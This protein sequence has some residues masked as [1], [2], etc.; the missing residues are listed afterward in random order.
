MNSNNPIHV[1][2]EHTFLSII[3]WFNISTTTRS[4]N[5][6]SSRFVCDTF[7]YSLMIDKLCIPFEKVDLIKICTD[8]LILKR[9]IVV[10]F[11]CFTCKRKSINSYPSEGVLKKY[12]PKRFS[13]K[14]S[15][16]IRLSLHDK[17]KCIIMIYQKFDR[18]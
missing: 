11:G 14:I 17:W 9:K 6:A 5:V 18:F 16:P 15:I 10:Q 8:F 13:S 3:G 12:V 1:T 4:K 7:S 2:N